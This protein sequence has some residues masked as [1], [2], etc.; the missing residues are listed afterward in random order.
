MQYDTTR[1]ES[2]PR[3]TRRAGRGTRRRRARGA[4][5]ARLPRRP[6]PSPAVD[7]PVTVADDLARWRAGLADRPDVSFR[8]YDRDNHMFFPGSGPSTPAEYQPAQHLDPA[9][10]TDIADWITTVRLAAI[11]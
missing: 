2:A 4:G 10:V 5:H 11:P 3:D 9:V 8:V 6:A 7:D 1:S